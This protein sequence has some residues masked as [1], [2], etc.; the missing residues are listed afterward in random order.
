MNTAYQK[1]FSQALTMR[2]MFG[3]S[4]N[5]RRAVQHVE[6]VIYKKVQIAPH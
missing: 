5:F 2:L 6:E 1:L 4:T 3:L